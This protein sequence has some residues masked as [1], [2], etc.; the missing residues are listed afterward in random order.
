[1]YSIG[2][3]SHAPFQSLLTKCSKENAEDRSDPKRITIVE[4][5][6]ATKFDEVEDHTD[7]GH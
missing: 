4:T 5:E 3:E 1:M 7:A 2:G 6:R